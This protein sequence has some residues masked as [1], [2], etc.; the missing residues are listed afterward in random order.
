MSRRTRAVGTALAT[1]LT[2]VILLLLTTT[3]LGCAAG[4]CDA[5]EDFYPTLHN[6]YKYNFTD[7]SGSKTDVIVSL[8]FWTKKSKY[9]QNGYYVS[10]DYYRTVSCADGTDKDVYD[11]SIYDTNLPSP[12][13]DPEEWNPWNPICYILPR[14]CNEEVEIG[15]QAPQ[16]IQL[17]TW[18][19]I[20]VDFTV[21][22]IDNYAMRIE[23]EVE[24]ATTI[25][26][27]PWEEWCLLACYD[28]KAGSGGW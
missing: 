2:A 25:T 18:Y 9:F 7:P 17:N 21:K 23:P 3:P 28:T 4:V 22:S 10:L 11:Y 8:L 14:I 15:M 16:N 24:P 13:V 27:P 1:A 6:H 20:R 26:P 12:R 5:E 19:Y